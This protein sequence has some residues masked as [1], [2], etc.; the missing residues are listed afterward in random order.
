MV[1]PISVKYEGDA[2][3]FYGGMRGKGNATIYTYNSTIMIE[4]ETMEG[5]AIIE[6]DISFNTSSALFYEE[7]ILS[8]SIFFSTSSCHIYYE[9]SRKLYHRISGS[10]EGNISMEMEG[11]VKM[12]EGKENATLLSILLPGEFTRAFPLKFERLFL[13]KGGKIW[14]NGE[15]KNFSDY[16]FFRGEGDYSIPYKFEGKAYMLA[17]DGEFYEEGKR[18][19][20]FPLKMVILWII[21]ISIFLVSLFIKKKMFEEKDEIFVGPAIIFPILFFAISFYLWN[22]NM[23]LIFGL[24]IF[25]IREINIVNVLFISLSIVPYLVSIGLIGFPARIAISS[26]SEIFG[27]SNLGKMVGRCIG[28]ILTTLWGLEMIGGVLNLTLSPLLRLI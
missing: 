19:F 5:N 23:E 20:F 25:Q 7:K 9:G 21:S 8:N 10:I 1:S 3:N 18:I 15:E 17:M 24:N 27:L 13:I 14:I 2:L 4:N 16:V 26:L 12:V 28:F 22:G 11:N 6:G